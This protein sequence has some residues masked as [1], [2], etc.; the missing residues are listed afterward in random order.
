MKQQT[1][2]QEYDFYE[3]PPH[4]LDALFEYLELPKQ[5]RII[6]P[7]SGD[8]AISELL[9]AEDHR[10]FTNDIDLKRSADSHMDA[11]E[12]LCWEAMTHE[13]HRPA[14]TI[15]NPPFDGIEPILRHSLMMSNN[16][17]SL[18]RLSFLEPTISRTTLYRMFGDPQ[19]V[20]VL[21]RYQ[22]S[23]PSKDT[24]TCC[25]VGWGKQVPKIFKIWTE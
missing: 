11:T 14:W 7:C 25:W 12:Y 9:K 1:A 8:G 24:M 18:A 22:F 3:T 17:I 10:V 5:S 4:Y 21:P 19:L 23:K 2:R 13:F 20:I 15:T 6:E 16:T